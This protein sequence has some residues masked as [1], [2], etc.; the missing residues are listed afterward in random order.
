[1]SLWGKTDTSGDEPK[2]GAA[3]NS[4]TS[5]TIEVFGVDATEQGVATAASGDAGKYAQC[6]LWMCLEGEWKGSI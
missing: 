6:Q 3:L 1:M 5:A 2:F 4:A